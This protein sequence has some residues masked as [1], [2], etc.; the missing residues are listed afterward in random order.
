[1]I[2]QAKKKDRLSIVRP[3]DEKY[4][5]LVEKLV[6]DTEPIEDPQ[7]VFVYSPGEDSSSKV[8]K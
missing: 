1:M 7:E 4:K 6:N 2:G 5:D 3:L 8:E